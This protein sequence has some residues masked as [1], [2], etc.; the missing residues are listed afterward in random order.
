MKEMLLSGGDDTKISE[1]WI[2]AHKK[3]E[4]LYI[5]W[6]LWAQDTPDSR[7]SR[8][9]LFWKDKFDIRLVGIH[10]KKEVENKHRAI[11]DAEMI[12]VGDGSIH[13]LMRSLEEEGLMHALREAILD[14]KGFI[15]IGAG[16]TLASPTIFTTFEPL[17]FSIRSFEALDIFPVQIA[18]H[19]YDDR[20]N[21][22]TPT[23]REFLTR[24]YDH[25]ESPY[26]V[27]GIPPNSSLLFSRGQ[28]QSY[29]ENPL[30]Y[31]Y[32]EMYSP[33][34]QIAQFG[35]NSD[36]TSLFPPEYYKI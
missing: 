20:H 22:S 21:E 23:P 19:Y 13:T 15:G 32:K 8:A 31:F 18:P 33:E 24:Y 28:V 34:I 3:T 2:K 5:P 36:L 17:L 1:D 4:A 11:H 7:F 14:G 35:P 6:A 30:T 9:K 29:G 27:L 26:P 12:I 25:N 16:A 10:S